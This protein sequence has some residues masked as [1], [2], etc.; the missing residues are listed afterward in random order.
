MSKRKLTRK[1]AWRI[2]KIQAERAK[3]AAKREANLTRDLAA[4]E[5][6]AEREGL[7]IAHFGSQVAVE[8]A[9]GESQ[10]CHIRANLEG[11][12]TGDRVIW[13]EGE[14]TGVVV[15]HLPRDSVLSRP[16]SQGKLKPVAANI[17]QIV[18]VLAALPQPHAN[19]I[20]RY[21]VAAETVG[22]EPVILLNKTD[23]LEGDPA[24]AAQIDKLLE[25]YPTLKY[26]LL[27]ASCQ[28][29]EG[30]QALFDGLAGRT[31]V[32]VGQSGVG[33]S[34][35]VNVL[36]PD[37]DLRVGALSESTQ[38]GTHTTTTARLFHLPSGGSL[39]DSPGIREFG[40][41]HMSREQVE[42]GFRE[43][44]P[45]LG[46]CKFRDCIHEREPDCAL[47]KA[48]ET[49]QISPGR[50]ASYRHMVATLDDVDGFA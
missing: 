37:T 41:W 45:L 29:S 9:S 21:L 25:V 7:V 38:K 46:N 50:L 34:S 49:G 33:K 35:L 12:V 43:F 10:R 31:S 48:A 23:I 5:L 1:Q 6:G 18:I 39:I 11:L 3:R 2:E 17:D 15:A 24:R 28:S 19:L 30:M 20:D 13:C 4:G 32:L 8:S 47:L 40:L 42:A 36:L 44:W 22:I 14:P 16:D 27:R 26:R